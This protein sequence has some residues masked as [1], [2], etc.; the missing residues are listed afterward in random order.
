MRRISN[1]AAILA[2]GFLATGCTDMVS[3]VIEGRRVSKLT[4]DV[5]NK[6]G[7]EQDN[8]IVSI[9][10][11]DGAPLTMTECDGLAHGTS[12]TL[13]YDI[14]YPELDVAA[15][16]HASIPSFAYFR[17][18]FRY[19]DNYSNTQV[20]SD[21]VFDLFNVVL[22]LID[23]YLCDSYTTTLTVEDNSTQHLVSGVLE[24][25]R[26]SSFTCSVINKS[27]CEVDGIKVTL[28]KPDGS[29]L[30]GPHQ[31]DDVPHGSTC[32]FTYDILV[33]N[34][35][36]AAYCHVEAPGDKWLHGNLRYEN[37]L[38][39]TLAETPLELSTVEM[40]TKMMD[41]EWATTGFL[42]CPDP[43]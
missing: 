6:S 37:N 18:S 17:G 11:L 30:A 29:V 23:T 42:S 26:V 38:S 36:V 3:G 28:K 39:A 7:L 10:D 43:G 13:S 20:V 40:M 27:G 22:D 34:L 12:C 5:V 31:C 41:L 32:N 25:R 1:L 4:C 21:M 16:C 8:V 33:P 19:E 15:Y 14:L 2:F 9:K 35:D 24:A